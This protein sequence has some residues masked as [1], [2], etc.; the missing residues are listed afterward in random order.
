MHKR[1]RARRLCQGAPLYS[2]KATHCQT[3]LRFLRRQREA[4]I[5]DLSA[6]GDI[7]SARVIGVRQVERLAVLTAIDLSI[8]APSLLDV[9]TRLLDHIRR[10]EPALQMAAAQLSL[11]VLLIAGT[12]QGLLQLHLVLGKLRDVLLRHW[13][14]SRLSGRQDRL[15]R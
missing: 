12:L 15:P 1:N 11:L 9:A 4:K 5:G 13:I 8:F 10:I 2:V 7:D 6:A 14:R 3:L